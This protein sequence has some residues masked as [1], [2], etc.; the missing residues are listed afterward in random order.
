MGCRRASNARDS[1]VYDWDECG[2][3]TPVTGVSSG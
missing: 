1:G 2:G 3:E